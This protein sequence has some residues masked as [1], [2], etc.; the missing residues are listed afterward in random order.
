MWVDTAPGSLR[1][2]VISSIQP[3]GQ[4]FPWNRFS[5]SFRKRN[6]TTVARRVERL[7][8]GEF[9]PVEIQKAVVEFGTETV[10]RYRALAAT[11]RDNDLPLGFLRTHV[12]VALAQ[13]FGGAV[14]IE[15]PYSVLALELGL[16][17]TP[18]LLMVLGDGRADV[19]MCADDK[20]V[21]LVT[22]DIFDYASVLPA[23]GAETHKAQVLRRLS[24]LPVFLGLMVCPV[25][26]SLEARL[27]RLHDAIGG[28][29]YVGER[30]SSQDGQWSWSFACASMV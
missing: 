14:R 13:R 23:L 29:L 22:L 15:R 3:V 26:A 28:N 27:E 10:K 21:A 8:P 2:C 4:A 11:K 17:P 30:E 7:E 24:K 5:P 6:N 20:P 12:A 16:Q 18:D 19:V 25:S 9:C 1:F